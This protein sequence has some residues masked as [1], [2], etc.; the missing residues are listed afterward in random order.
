ML[1]VQV[2]PCYALPADLIVFGSYRMQQDSSV[3]PHSR[4]WIWFA[5][6]AAAVFAGIVGTFGLHT[7]GSPSTILVDG[8]PLVTVESRSAAVEL[9]NDLR[10]SGG[11]EARFVEQ[12]AYRPAPRDAAVVLAPE[13]RSAVE[14][15]V[16]IQTRKWVIAANDDPIVGLPN[17]SDAEKALSLLTTYYESRI[18][19][20]KIRS[21]FKEHVRIV[22][23]FVD[24]S[25]VRS[26]PDEAVQVLT[27]MSKEPAYHVVGMGDRASKLAERYKLSLN[28]LKD[29]NPGV[30]L[31]RILIGDKLKIGGGKVPI[32][33]VSKAEVTKTMDVSAPGRRDRARSGKRK[34]EML[35][36]YENGVEV[37]ED[38]LSQ[39]TT[40]ERP[41]RK[42][43]K[44]E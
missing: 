9:I 28:D 10:E 22:N 23:H 11:G 8:R 26:T 30:N 1:G 38:L 37:R 27:S 13:A 17:K 39:V 5:I 4:R 21:D 32:T 3:I 34:V 12:V 25:K 16:H 20:K 6:G 31:D 43:M 42:T 44:Y 29:L 18:S 19:V 33:V 41:A 24:L 36:T 15:C 2:F 40:W 7:S 14:K 35:V